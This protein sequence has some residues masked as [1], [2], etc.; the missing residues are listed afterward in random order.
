M[1]F[2]HL[3]IPLADQD[4]VYIRELMVY[5]VPEKKGEEESVLGGGGVEEE[6]YVEVDYGKDT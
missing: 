1:F 5:F 6:E 4:P 2:P 3:E